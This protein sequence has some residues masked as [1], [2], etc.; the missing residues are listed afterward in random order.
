MARK[1]SNTASEMARQISLGSD[2]D[3]AQIVDVTIALKN[4]GDGLSKAMAVEPQVHKK[5]DRVRII[6]D[7]VVDAIHFTPMLLRGG[8]RDY[9]RT[10]RHQVI[11]AEQATFVGAEV[12]AEI[13]EA[14][15][16]ALDKLAGQ[17]Q[18]PEVVDGGFT[19]EELAEH[20]PRPDDWDDDA[21]N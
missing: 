20:A 13:M 21:K 9:T 17:A 5:G 12:G 10:H 3:G 1:F 19:D 4:A 2:P 14:H 7:G 6:I 8:E 15:R 11:V 16:A 18:I